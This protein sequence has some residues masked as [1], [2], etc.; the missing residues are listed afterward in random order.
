MAVSN[1]LI[2]AIGAL[3]AT[4]QPAALSNLVSE[5]TGVS[6][7]AI[8]TNSPLALELHKIEEQDDAAAVEVDQWIQPK[9]W[10]AAIK[11]PV[12]PNARVEPPYPR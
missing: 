11:A 5:T 6:I 8:D 3:L 10:N 1:L 2:G 12:I 4:N 7:T 9:R